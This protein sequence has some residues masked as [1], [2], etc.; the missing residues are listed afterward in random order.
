[1]TDI[2]PTP[3]RFRKSEYWDTP[4]VDS[5]TNRKAHRTL[6]DVTRAWRAGKIEFAHFQAWESFVRHYEG[7][8]R[9]DVRVSDTTGNGGDNL[10]RMPPWQWH[11]IKISQARDDLVPRQFQVMELLVLGWTFKQVGF[12]LSAY[13]SR[14]QAEAYALGVIEDA[15]ERLALLWGLKRRETRMKSG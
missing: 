1:M 13:K 8:L 3:E 11:G 9:H 12:Q 10:D 6:D 2:G 14:Q 4:E 5:K 7:A 15:L